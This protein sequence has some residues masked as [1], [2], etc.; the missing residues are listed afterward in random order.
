MRPLGGTINVRPRDPFR[1][2]GGLE[3]AP[4]PVLMSRTDR[5]ARL[6][7]VPDALL[8][9]VMIKGQWPLGRGGRRDSGIGILHE[10]FGNRAARASMAQNG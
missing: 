3:P 8:R 10:G 5:D 2:P 7:I 1:P 4:A 9:T 6:R